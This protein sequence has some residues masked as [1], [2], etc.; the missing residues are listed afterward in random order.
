MSRFSACRGSE[1]VRMST[2]SSVAF[3]KKKQAVDRASR[4][5]SAGHFTAKVTICLV[6]ARMAMRWR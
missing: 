2:R 1:A 6:Q 5:A 3:A 4:V